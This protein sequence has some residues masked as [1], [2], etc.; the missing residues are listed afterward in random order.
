MKHSLTRLFTG[1]LSICLALSFCVPTVLATEAATPDIVYDFSEYASNGEY[2]SD[3][4]KNIMTSYGAKTLNWRYEAAFSTYQ[5][6]IKDKHPDATSTGKNLFLANSMQFLGAKGWWYALRLRAPDTGKYALTLNKTS[7]ATIEVYFFDA[8]PLDMA[9]GDKAAEYA[10]MMS[11]DPYL[12]GGTEAFGFYKENI[13]KMMAEATPVMPA[14]GP[15]VSQM[16]GEYSFGAGREYIMVVNFVSEDS[17]RIQLSSLSAT[18]IGEAENLPVYDEKEPADITVILVP[19]II[20]AVV[21]GV[22]TVAITT[23]KKSP[24]KTEE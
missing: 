7:A 8:T 5:F 17:L 11:D 6:R 15:D 22:L 16:T 9:M 23:R 20:V 10:L 21:V 14:A 2:L 4:A 3:C 18:R 12:S 24:K 19:V 13:E 1:L